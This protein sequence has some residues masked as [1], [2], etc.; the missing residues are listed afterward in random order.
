MNKPESP[1][2]DTLRE[3]VLSSGQGRFGGRR[4]LLVG[5]AAAVLV[6]AAGIAL[7]GNGGDEWP[8]YRT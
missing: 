2:A 6:L 4:R 1:S 8:R 3:L 7:F 5:G